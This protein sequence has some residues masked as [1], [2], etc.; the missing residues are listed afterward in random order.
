[1]GIDFDITTYAD[2]DL[3]R[4]E[5]AYGK[6][7]ISVIKKAKKVNIVSSFT[8]E[9]IKNIGDEGN[10]ININTHPDLFPYYQ[11]YFSKDNT[12]TYCH[13]PMAKQYIE[14]KNVEYLRRDLRIKCCEEQM[15]ER[16]LPP[17]DNSKNQE[18]K[19]F[20]SIRR[21]Y[22]NLMKNSTVITNSEFSRRA[23]VSVLNNGAD[24]IHVIRPPVDIETFR[25]TVLYSSL[26]EKRDDIILIVSRIHKSKEIEN[27]VRLAVLLKENNIGSG[28]KII[29]NINPEYDWNYYLS[30][31]KMVI[32]FD[33][34]DYVNFE[35]NISLT[36]LFSMMREAK[37][38]F[39][40]MVGEHFGM[41]VV[42]SMAAGLVPIVPDVGG[43]TEFVPEKYHFNTLEEAAEKISSAFHIS[44][45]ERF[46]LSNS[47]NKF[48]VSTYIR[49]FQGIVSGLT[50]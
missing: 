45:L 16:I 6:G 44:D 43:P 30:L 14:S 19:Y 36:D 49:E 40:P 21:S 50:P 2:P 26:K 34:E 1:M 22:E 27:A 4:L 3:S 32:E 28:M 48:S 12:I 31:K 24:E 46:R 29:G 7:L 38:Y 41:S 25:N 37:I 9:N 10:C 20:V 5:N 47:V 11:E 23:I 18:D 17:D 8:Q 35:T 13:F 15:E 42:E 33:L 39:H